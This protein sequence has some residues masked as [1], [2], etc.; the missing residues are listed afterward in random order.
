MASALRQRLE[1]E[2]S[3]MCPALASALV[4]FAGVGVNT[5]MRVSEESDGDG[6]RRRSGGGMGG[7]VGGGG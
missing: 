4:F 5:L 3:P 6:R 1:I 2:R 7:V